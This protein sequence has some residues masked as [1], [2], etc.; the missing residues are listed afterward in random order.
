METSISNHQS[1]GLS[2]HDVS[3]D[4]EKQKRAL[5][6]DVLAKYAHLLRDRITASSNIKP[7]VPIVSV[8]GSNIASKGDFSV[9]GGLPKAG[10][11]S[12]AVPM[13][14]T[15]L[16][17]NTEGID[18]LSIRTRF[19]EGKPVV[20]FDTEQPRA[21]TDRFRQR[22]LQMLGVNTEPPNLYIV[23]LRQYSCEEKQKKILEW[24]EFLPD[25]HLWIID[26]VADLIRDPNET[27]DAFGI[28]EKL[29]IQSD[30]L[31]TTIIGFIHENPGSSGKL[32][33][34]LGSEAERKC[35]GAITVKRLKDKDC[36]CIQ[37]K[38]IRGAKDFEEIYFNY[39]NTLGRMA[40]LNAADS[41]EVSRTV[42][43]K[44]IKHE[45]LITLAKKCLLLDRLTYGDLV[46]RIL[47]HASEVEG[48]S[49]KERTAQSRV[50]ELVVAGVIELDGEFY[51]L[52]DKYKPQP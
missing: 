25:T 32:R 36:Y 26:G 20:Y 6:E 13:I 24:M 30:K 50:K 51:T 46:T 22:V 34:N 45:R 37:A 39:D 48:K 27:K 28:I 5:E 10:K 11:T 29:M 17:E 18:S 9:V 19:C 40:S 38:L 1:N 47:T 16:I 4:I 33:G 21:Y 15:A 2:I 12:I 41:A 42:D 43:K 44:Q 3:K 14:A 49:I 52:T 23:N 31:D 8:S 7:I 35:G